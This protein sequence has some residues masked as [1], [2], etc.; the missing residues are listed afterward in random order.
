M[1]PTHPACLDPDAL[2]GQCAVSSG[3]SGGPGGQRRNKVETAVRITHRPT[4]IEAAATERRQ[5]AHNRRVAVWRLRLKL[6][7]EVRCPIGAAHHASPLW[8]SRCRDGRIAVNPRHEDFPALLAEALDV[9]EGHGH[10]PVP[11]AAALGCSTSQLIKLIRK[12]PAAFALI[13][14]RRRDRGLHALR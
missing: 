13:N 14:Q 10:D 12:E 5:Q 2:L 8:M 11:A 1:T 3:R 7:L 6:A 4:A 9:L